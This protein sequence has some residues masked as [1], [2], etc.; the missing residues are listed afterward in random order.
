M[1]VL[2][3][4]VLVLAIGCTPLATPT[5]SPAHSSPDHT[6]SAPATQPTSPTSVQPPS[7]PI[8][9]AGEIV[10]ARS[11]VARSSPDA[12]SSEQL[13][14][15]VGAD[16]AFAFDLYQALAAQE[17][18]NIFTS[19]YSIS[20]ALFMVLAGARGQTAEELAD[21]LGIPS[22]DPAWHLARNRL[23]MELAALADHQLPGNPDAVPLTIELTNAIFGQAG[24]PFKS[25]YLDTLA[26]N[27]GAG[28][29]AVDFAA[30]TEAARLA[31]NEWVAERTKER[32]EELLAPGVID[33][34][35]RA[36]LVN[37]I[38][39]K[40]NWLLQ[41]DTQDTAA[42]PFH[43]LDGSRVE[44]STMHQSMKWQY[45]SGEG[46]AAV[47]LPYV[48]NASMLVIV[49]DEG[50]FAEIEASL[51]DERL[52]EITDGLSEHMVDLRLPRWES[53]SDLDLIPALQ[54]LGVELLFGAADLTGIADTGLFVSFVRHA[55]NI[56]VDEMGTEAAAATAVGLA[57]S[58]A[59]PATLT[60]DRPFMYLIRDRA[61]GEILFLGRLLEP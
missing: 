23:D 59:P 47:E 24:Y 43:L 4:A 61:N 49:P 54:S 20:T 31:I 39:F 28:M 37:A 12:S 13:A 48:G 8:G 7:S 32:I 53:E 1:R 55:A 36:V 30:Q 60:V 22:D 11:D 19:P 50:R 16:R 6:P 44:V 38:Y 41:F 5:T 52:Q 57:E 9:Q 25:D 18:G 26:A 27:Y 42:A 29:H 17:S 3:A 15:L 34:K 46:W 45:A 51:D 58:A 56:T 35:T 40:A 2:A 33:D 21:A 10:E 14:E